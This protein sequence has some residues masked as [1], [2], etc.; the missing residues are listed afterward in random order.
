MVKGKKILVVKH[1]G[2][3][4]PYDQTKVLRSI[5][6][7]QVGDERAREILTKVEQKLFNGISTKELYR[8]VNREIVKHDLPDCAN[9]YRLREAV[10][11]MDSIDFERFI[12]EILERE[13]FDS[14]WNL[15]IDGNCIDHQIDVIAKSS[16][17]KVYMVEVKHH[18]RFH[19]DSDLGTVVE[20]WGRLEDL[21][22]GFQNKKN[23][24]EFE[25][26]WLITNTKFSQHAKQYA[27][28]KNLRLTGWHY[29]LKEKGRP[30]SDEGLEREFEALGLE[31]VSA[32]VAKV[33]GKVG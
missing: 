6:R 24:F 28:C 18:R 19:R 25:T 27:A 14:Q 23:Q 16:R 22:S 13:G 7:S 29:S 33:I 5:S 4:E 3:K 2:T 21:K 8:L 11:A 12:R 30:T 20:V 15:K 1:S 26:A 32:L 17:G 9:M 10:A 31:Q